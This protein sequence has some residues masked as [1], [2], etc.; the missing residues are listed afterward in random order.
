VDSI[1][2][3]DNSTQR[4]LAQTIEESSDVLQIRRLALAMREQSITVRLRQLANL[5]NI[6]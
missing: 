6:E 5:D 3:T 4:C 1:T 2:D